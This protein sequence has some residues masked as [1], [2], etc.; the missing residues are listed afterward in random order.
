LSDSDDPPRQ[1]G[2]D[3]ESSIEL[4]DRVR[5]GDREAMDRLFVR[6]LGPLC[7]WAHG[8]L[9][10]WARTMSDTQDVV[11]DGIVRVLNHLHTFQPDGPGALHW[12]LR[13][14]VLNRIR[15]ELRKVKRHP[16]DVEL[17]DD[18]ASA[19]PSPYDIAA[20]E[21]DRE[22][23]ERALKELRE[24]QREL[25]IARLEWGLEYA[26]I[27]Q[28]LGKPSPDAARVA[29]RRAVVKLAEDMRRL[30]KGGAV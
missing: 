15:D 11:Q 24:E 5:S 28:A 13:T 3:G 9:P 23:F 19:V 1:Q 17:E 18:F 25:V 4:L 6:Y 29:V 12:Y 22:M 30:R 27:A 20:M 16:V 2:P 8:R 21:E 10:Q 14:A 26:E 7:K